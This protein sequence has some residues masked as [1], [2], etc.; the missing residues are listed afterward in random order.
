MDYMICTYYTGDPDAPVSVWAH[1]SNNVFAI[2]NR[3]NPQG[4]TWYRHDA[5]HSLGLG[6]NGSGLFE[7]RLLTDPVDRSIGQQWRHF[8]P[9]WLHLQLTVNAEY[10]LEFADRV[11]GYFSEGGLLSPEANNERWDERARQI[12]LAVIA[13]SA[14]WGDSRSNTPR[15]KDDWQTEVNWV[16]NSFF[17]R[18]ADIVI[19]D[20]RSV[21]MFRISRSSRSTSAA[22]TSSRDSSWS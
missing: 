2:Y 22:A 5:E 8:N 7:S 12:E 10:A 1:F 11:N 20:M 9:A 21:G 17:P 4:F 18:R 16:R 14:R 3:E 6:L 13:A 19:G 15:T